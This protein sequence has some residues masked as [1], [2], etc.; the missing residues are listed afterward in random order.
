MDIARRSLLDTVDILAPVLILRV[1]L[2][3]EVVAAIFIDDVI[4]NRAILGCKELARLA[5]ESGEV[6]IGIGIVADECL[7][8]ATLQGEVYHILLRLVIIDS[9]RCPHPIGIGKVLRKVLRKI[10][11]RV[12]PVD[13][14]IRLEQYD[15]RIAAPALLGVE[16]VHVGSHDVIAAILATQNVGVSDA[17]TLAD[18]VAGDDGA[19][20]IQGIPVHCIFT[21]GEAQLLLLA[22]I[23][24]TLKVGKEI[25]SKVVLT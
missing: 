8:I 4:I 10:D 17:T 24:A 5:L 6:R 25:T 16:G 1:A 22:A 18:G 15:T 19:V 23:A 21:D 9:L 3:E 7:T 20:A 11:L 12:S 14:V 13:K 2:V